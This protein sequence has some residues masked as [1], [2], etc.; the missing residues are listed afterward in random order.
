MSNSVWQNTIDAP[1]TPH[2]EFSSRLPATTVSLAATLALAAGIISTEVDTSPRKERH[3]RSS[4]TQC[5]GRILWT[6]ATTV[7]SQS[8]QRLSGTTVAS[9]AGLEPANGI[10]WF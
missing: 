9:A 2:S 1:V 3:L 8:L 5:S 6:Y 7:Y 4:G 10:G